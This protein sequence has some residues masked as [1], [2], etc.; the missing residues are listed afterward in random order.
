MGFSL[1]RSKSSRSKAHT[2]MDRTDEG[3]QCETLDLCVVPKTLFQR[4]NRHDIRIK[5]Y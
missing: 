2:S 5:H 3:S 1:R 4:C